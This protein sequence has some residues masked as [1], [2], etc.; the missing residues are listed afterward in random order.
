MHPALRSWRNDPPPNIV[1]LLA[2]LGAISLLSMAGAHFSKSPKVMGAITPVHQGW[3][4]IRR[5]F[6]AFA[7]CWRTFRKSTPK[8]TSSRWEEMAPRR[9]SSS[10][11]MT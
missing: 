10:R 7:L 1:R 6:A 2:Y 8:P 4:D 9:R 3:I 5:P 11:S